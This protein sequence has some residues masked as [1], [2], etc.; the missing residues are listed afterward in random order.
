MKQDEVIQYWHLTSFFYPSLLH[1]L[2]PYLLNTDEMI[3][4]NTVICD[5][6]SFLPQI[7][8]IDSEDRPTILLWAS[9]FPCMGLVLFKVKE[10]LVPDRSVSSE[11]DLP[12]EKSQAYSIWDK[13]TALNYLELTI[14]FLPWKK[15]GWISYL[16]ILVF[17]VSAMNTLAMYTL[18]QKHHRK[19]RQEKSSTTQQRG[20][21][22]TR[23]TSLDFQGTN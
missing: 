15:E 18:V 7:R 3:Q 11:I 5:S 4:L 16:E 17:P 1:S 8:S 10:G 13:Q 14:G 22:P 12:P 20:Y 21:I 19:F 23:A 9:S 2:C 6:S